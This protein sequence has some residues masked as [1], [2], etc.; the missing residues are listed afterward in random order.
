[1]ATKRN[2]FPL[3]AKT[4]LLEADLKVTQLAT[5][6]GWSRQAVSAALNGS[7][8]YPHVTAAIAAYLHHDPKTDGPLPVSPARPERRER[9]AGR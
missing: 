4:R 8:H 3:W 2:K 5:A 6:L 7:T 1:M 9:L